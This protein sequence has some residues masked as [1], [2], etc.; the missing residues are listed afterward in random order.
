M[1]VPRRKEVG[2]AGGR[3]SWEVVLERG[4]LWVSG[5]CTLLSCTCFLMGGQEI[6]HHPGAQPR[7]G[8]E[9]HMAYH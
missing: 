1:T 2:A 9:P 3:G 4:Q 6:T 7:K 5:Y 8:R